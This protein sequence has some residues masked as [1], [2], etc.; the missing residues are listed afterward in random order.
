MVPGKLGMPRRI[1]VV[2]PAR[3]GLS[4]VAAAVGRVLSCG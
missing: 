2:E 4:A 1:F 3:C